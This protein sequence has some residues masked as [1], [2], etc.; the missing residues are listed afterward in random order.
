[1]T[2]QMDL[3]EVIACYPIDILA[4]AAGQLGTAIAEHAASEVLTTVS[5][6]KIR[7]ADA[8]LIA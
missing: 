2:L 7:A 6:K 5:G 8:A 4:H 1:M 3:V